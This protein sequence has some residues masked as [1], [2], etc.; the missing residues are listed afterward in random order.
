MPY[1]PRRTKIKRSIGDVPDEIYYAF[2][3]DLGY[4]FGDDHGWRRQQ[5]QAALLKTWKIYR[6]AIIER[7]LDSNKKTARPGRRP[8]FYFHELEKKHPRLFIG[9]ALVWRPH[10]T[11]PVPEGK[12]LFED[13]IQYLTRLNLLEDWEKE[14][15]RSSKGQ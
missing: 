8:A 7:D 3:S 12:D 15:I 9:K 13:N 1:K 11:G 2:S 14:A 6:Q 10:G 4:L 5:S